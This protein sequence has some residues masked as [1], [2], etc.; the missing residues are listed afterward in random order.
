MEFIPLIV[1]LIILGIFFGYIETQVP[2]SAPFKYGVQIVGVLIVLLLL[3]RVLQ[4]IFP[5]LTF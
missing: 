4:R 3:L 1:V 5:H 2:M